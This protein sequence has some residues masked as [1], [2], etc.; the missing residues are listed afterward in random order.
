MSVTPEVG[1]GAVRL[2]LGR[3][4]TAEEID[5]VAAGLVAA[6]RAAPRALGVSA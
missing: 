6:V 1:M 5:A 4:T 2:S 3:F